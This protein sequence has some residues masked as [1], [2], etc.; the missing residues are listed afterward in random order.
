MRCA[1]LYLIICTFLRRPALPTRA[2]NQSQAS[3]ICFR[4]NSAIATWQKDT[5]QK[6]NGTPR[7][8]SMAPITSIPTGAATAKKKAAIV[9]VLTD[10]LPLR[11]FPF[12]VAHLSTQRRYNHVSLVGGSR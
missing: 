11:A 4:A 8:L 6:T 3:T 10:H 9:R 2:C 7:P 12:S 1:S 5:K